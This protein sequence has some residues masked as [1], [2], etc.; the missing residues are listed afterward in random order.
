MKHML[1][2]LASEVVQ[3]VIPRSLLLWELRKPEEYI[4]NHQTSSLCWRWSRLHHN[5]KIKDSNIPDISDETYE[6]VKLDYS[7]EYQSDWQDAVNEMC[8]S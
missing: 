3:P 8:K 4:T 1:G 6:H 5:D 7:E 2:I